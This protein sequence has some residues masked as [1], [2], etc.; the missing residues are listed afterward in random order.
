[1][2][3][4]MEKAMNALAG[5]G[6]AAGTQ[7]GGGDAT[8]WKA[9][10]EE[11]QRLLNSARVEQG[12]V[13][14]LDEENKALQRQL[15]DE[16][17]SRRTQNVIDGLPDEVKGDVPDDYLKAQAEIARRTADQAL[18]SRDAEMEA[19]KA[20]LAERDERDVAAR[21][22][23]FAARI[24]REFPGFFR[25]AVSEVGDK[26]AAW[27]QYQR[28]NAPSIVAATRSFDFDSL[29]WH[30]Q[31]FYQ[32]MLG[33]AAPSGG[34]GAAAPDP[35]PTGGGKPV[36]AETQKTYTAQEYA[37][38]EK[39]AMRLRRMGDYAAYRK[40]DEELSNILAEGRVKD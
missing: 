6:A 10:Y 19:L 3:E 21:R 22:Q 30:I 11:T 20:Q 16:R 27:V 24:D 17:A 13:K 38:L 5:D 18:A 37:E 14:K 35:S 1:M 31:Q 29:S 36:H 8:D 2:N 12:R 15:E 40:L 25:D 4:E 32:N 34:T 7:P 26:H 39:K 9:K 28:Y 33:I 23:Q